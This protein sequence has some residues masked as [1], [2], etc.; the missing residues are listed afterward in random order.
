VIEPSLIKESIWEL[1]LI[2]AVLFDLEYNWSWIKNWCW[3]MA[4]QV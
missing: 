2:V 4:F 1:Q 3:P